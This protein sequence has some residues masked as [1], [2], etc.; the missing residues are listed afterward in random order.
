[1]H[2]SRSA[3]LA[4]TALLAGTAPAAAALDPGPRCEVTAAAALASCVQ[5]VGRRVT[6]CY[7]DTGGACAAA[8]ASVANGLSKLE[9]RVLAACPDAATLQAAGYGTLL[10]PATL[11]ERLRAACLGEPASI[12]ARTFGGPQAAVLAGA[13][14][15]ARRCL[16]VASTQAVKLVKKAARSRGACIRSTR[17]GG[18]CD[19]ARTASQVSAAENRALARIDDACPTLKD[20]I[21]L[22]A[23][24]LV[25]RADAQARCMVATGHADTAPLDLD[26]GP[27]IGLPVPPRGQWVQVTLDEAV[28]GTRC[29]DGTP[30]A[31]W[32]RLA[33]SGSS[34]ANVAV[35][36]AGGGVC[37]FEADCLGVPPGLFNALDDGQPGGGYLNTTSAANPFRDWTMLYLPYCTQDVHIG[38]GTT[39]NFPGI[40]VHRFG[41]VNVRAALRYLR[42][43]LWA[44]L[45]A[46]TAEGFRPDLLRVLFAGESAGAFGVSYNYHYLLDD[47]GWSHTTAAPD[48]G[49]GLDNPDGLGVRDLGII[50][51]L[52]T[53][54]LGWG[55]LPYQAPYCL[56]ADCAVVPE[57]QAATAPRLKAVPE[58]QILNLSNQVDSTQVGTTFFP[59][60]TAWID[61]MRAAYC[62]NQGL[63][64]I[65]AF[66][67]ASSSSIHTMLRGDSTFTTLLAGGV[68][69][70]Q[71][72][73]DAVTN[74]DGVVD[75][76]DEGTIVAD[77][78]A[79]PFVC[80]P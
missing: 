80:L 49:L 26:C 37:I 56:G 14:E 45:D 17:A 74:P 13:D 61:A 22:D 30:F 59:D 16:S 5:R 63:N 70:A 34:A 62:V 66:L 46:T 57:L 18:S 8:D 20:L 50:L 51:T 79:Q 58:Q 39:S 28:W 72:L 52:D 75:R 54:P 35:D 65:H 9:R 53:P 21:G 68:S 73:G 33:P 77:F 31:F 24:L 32:L 78:G 48:S 64:G 2:S 10:T 44:E 29:G 11:V 55:T 67:P 25:A 7:L 41:A 27:R 60:T 42:D 71:W 6:R 3:A 40:T 47:L 1:M 15:D 43:V 38:G 19:L 76:V 23:S 12:A 36:L 4:L 69:S